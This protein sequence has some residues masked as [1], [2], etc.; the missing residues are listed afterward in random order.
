METR[1]VNRDKLRKII[2]EKGFT[3]AYLA[4]FLGISRPRM[5]ARLKDHS[6]FTEEEIYRLCKVFGNDI[7]NL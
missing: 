3:Q 4:K 7:L 2:S 5:N 1:I 6:D